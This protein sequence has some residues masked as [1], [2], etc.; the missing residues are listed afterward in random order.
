M[1]DLFSTK[2]SLECVETGLIYFTA[3]KKQ[4]KK[5]NYDIPWKTNTVY[6]GYFW[7]F[8]SVTD[9]F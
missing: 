8:S 7:E 1:S 5:N 2:I 6:V 4:Q 3:S 9:L